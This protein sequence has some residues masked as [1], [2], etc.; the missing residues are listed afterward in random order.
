MTEL[1]QLKLRKLLFCITHYQCWH[2]LAHGVFPSLEHY[3]IIKNLEFELLIDVGA[4]KG[5]FSSMVRLLHRDVAIEA[6]EPLSSEAEIYRKL[7]RN[8]EGVILNPVAVGEVCGEAVLHVSG[9]RDSSSLLPIGRLQTDFFPATRET[10]ICTVNVVTLDSFE[11]RWKS[12]QRALLKIDVQG[13]EFLVLYGAKKTLQH[14]AYVYV[15]CSHALLYDGQHL[16]LEVAVLL[17]KAG[18]SEIRRENELWQNGQLIQAD[19]LFER[20]MQNQAIIH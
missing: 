4:H 6:F 17:N 15:E 10:G 7:F 9:A 16:Y 11:G 20:Q 13:Y 8:Q 2:G 3:N 18:F 5:Q 19:Y 14:C 1:L 12:V